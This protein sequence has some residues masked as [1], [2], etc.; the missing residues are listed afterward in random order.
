LPVL[1]SDD[2]DAL[3]TKTVVFQGSP[4]P[5]DWLLGVWYEAGAISRPFRVI[6][7]LP[8]TP[9]QKV[10]P[11]CIVNPAGATFPIRVVSPS[12]VS[13]GNLAVEGGL[14]DDARSQISFPAAGRV[15]MRTPIEDPRAMVPNVSGTWY[16]QGL[17]HLRCTI[18]Q[19]GRALV[20]VDEGLRRDAGAISLKGTVS[21]D[22]GRIATTVSPVMIR[23]S[24]G[25][26]W[27]R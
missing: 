20:F 15:F 6:K 9:L 3:S 23:W 16:P 24:D 22:G 5:D 25:S 10:S 14:V 11:L 4:A 1:P 12:V 18:Q 27:S 2:D 21:T 13:C 17:K 26:F 19:S 8:G 7:S